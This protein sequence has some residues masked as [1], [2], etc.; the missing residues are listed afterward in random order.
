[1]PARR[2]GCSPYTQPHGSLTCQML[3]N[4]NLIVSILTTTALPK[5]ALD[6]WCYI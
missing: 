5:E 1:M 3:H 2:T 6:I 4:E